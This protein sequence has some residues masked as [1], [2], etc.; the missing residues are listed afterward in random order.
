MVN[1]NVSKLVNQQMIIYYSIF[2][3]ALI[4]SF[5]ELINNNVNF[6]KLN[7]IVRF[8]FIF[9]LIFFIGFRF[10]VGA[11]WNTYLDMLVYDISDPPIF[12]SNYEAGFSSLIFI[13]QYFNFGIFAINFFSACVFILGYYFLFG[14]SK[15]FWIVTCM[16][17]PYL[18]FIVGMG[19]TRQSIA[20]GFIMMMLV[21]DKENIFFQIVFLVFAILF[22]NAAFMMSIF[23]FFNIKNNILKIIIFCLLI[24]ILFILTDQFKSLQRFYLY[25]LLV[26]KSSAGAFPRFIYALLPC[27]F[28]LFFLKKI[29]YSK[30]CM[31][32][33]SYFLVII[34]LF[35][36][37]LVSRTTADRLLLFLLPVQF[38]LIISL[39]N[40]IKHKYKFIFLYFFIFLQFLQMHL[41]FLY[42]SNIQTWFPY[43]N[44]LILSTAPESLHILFEDWFP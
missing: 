32:Y 3:L 12:K 10:Q 37:I 18:I 6:K 2:S 44:Y 16:A 43:K 22:H 39:S 21:T 19:Y 15:F 11:D 17:L 4:L 40:F 33:L 1:F 25:Y 26:G 27:F 41:L 8:F 23:L 20:V 42:S 38:L 5:I 34:L 36:I 31:L 9:F 29:Y 35:F 13:V 28:S 24:L 7:N 30:D 14:K